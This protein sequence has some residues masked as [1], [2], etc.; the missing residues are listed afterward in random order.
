ME[1][2]RWG[3][4]GPGNIANKF[5]KAVKNV[6]GAQLVAV[7]ARS[8]EK[9]QAFA[10]N[11]GI[12]RV[13]GSFEEMAF[14]DEV[15]AVYVSTPHPVHKDCAEIFLQ[16]GKHVLCEKPLCV[17]AKQARQLRECAKAHDVFLM[18]AIWTR[19][20]PAVLELQKI[21]ASGELG[22][23]MGL[24]ADFCYATTVE[25]E[26]KLFQN[27]IA[28][29][30]LLDVGIYGLN[31]AALLFGPQPQEIHAVSH[32][33]DGVDLHTQTVLKYPNGAM[34]SITSAIA[35]RKPETAYIYGTKGYVCLP[36]F[37]G[38]QE[39]IVNTDGTDRRILKP[40]MGEGFEEEILEVCAC[41]RAGKKESDTMPLNET[42]RILEWMD[43]I[44][45]KISVQ[46]PFDQ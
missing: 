4:A 33:S 27:H 44:R 35:L 17:N 5:A 23:V 46:Y 25:E 30:S 1:T 24:E 15:D 22:Q 37:Y 19:F 2:I 9:G 39:L 29:G 45:K 31:L 32:V 41:I 7:A 11:H 40:S 42:I 38:A 21:I 34:A 13:F 36:T 26:A 43:E 8:L 3:I 28:G 12:A 14:S 20:L 16:A 18:E 10:Q 6:E